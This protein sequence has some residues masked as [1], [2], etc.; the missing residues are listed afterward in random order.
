[1]HT[2]R[3]WGPLLALFVLAVVLLGDRG[4]DADPAGGGAPPEA[5]PHDRSALPCQAVL[6]WR[7]GRVDDRWGL[8]REDVREAARRASRAWEA[9]AGRPLFRNDPDDGLP[10]HLEYDERQVRAQD[11]ERA[12]DSARAA[13][14]DSL[15][16][17]GATRRGLERRSEE[18]SREIR[19]HNERVEAVN[20]DP[21]VPEAERQEILRNEGDLERE[22]QALAERRTAFE[23]RAGRPEREEARLQEA[24]E[25]HNRS[26]EVGSPTRAGDYWEQVTTRGDRVVAV[27]DRTITV[28]WFADT[29]VL[30]RVIAHELGHALGLGHVSGPLAVMAEMSEIGGRG[31]DLVVRTADRAELRRRCPEL[32]EVQ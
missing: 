10:I 25:E 17:L 32:V 4:E 12:L 3:R 2:L 8:D 24:I 23:R 20:R 16:V 15:E 9:A 18:L 30:A 27:E 26:P 13:L 31:D 11:R 19:R 5:L 1:M 22:Q 6:G 29:T 21:P 7:I 28:R 14:S